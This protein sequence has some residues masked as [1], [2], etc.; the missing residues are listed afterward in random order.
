MDYVIYLSYRE[1]RLGPH[2]PG[3]LLRWATAS[4]APGGAVSGSTFL[5]RHVYG[6]YLRDTLAAAKAAARPDSRLSL[7]HSQAIAIR[8]TRA[9]GPLQVVLTDGE[10]RADVVVLATG[11][12][13]SRLP[14]ATPASNRIIADPRA[15]GA[16]DVQADGLPVVIVGTG[17]TMIDLAI[18]ITTASPATGKDIPLSPAI[19]ALQRWQYF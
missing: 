7:I 8:R 10:V 15:P 11:N 12:A 6:Q 3:H 1:K 17:L 19:G 4:L 18:A 9:A 16:L 5:P 2:D 14:F 13:A